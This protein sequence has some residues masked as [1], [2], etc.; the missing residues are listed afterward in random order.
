VLTQQ[1]QEPIT[2]DDDDD[3]NNNNNNNNSILYFNVLHQQPNGQLQIQH[4][5]KNYNNIKKKKKI[6][7]KQYL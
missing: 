2:N 5:E 3:D 7:K 6:I 4:K 1:Q